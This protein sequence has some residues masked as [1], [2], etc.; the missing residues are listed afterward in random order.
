[1]TFSASKGVYFQVLRASLKDIANRPEMLKHRKR[2]RENMS[3]STLKS[4]YTHLFDCLQFPC[5]ERENW[6]ALK[7]D[8]EKLAQALLSYTTYMQKSNKRVLLNHMN[9][10]PVRQIADNITFQFLPRCLIGGSSQLKDLSDKLVASDVFE[11][12]AIESEDYC[13][14]ES[15]EKYNFIKAMKTQGFPFFTALMTYTHGKNVGKLNFVWK[16]NSIDES[17]FLTVSR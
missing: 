14:T 13:P 15:H 6:K 1:M 2:N 8:I 4:L 16:V 11:Y 12:I 5:W 17:S 10:S 9:P 3:C 7:P